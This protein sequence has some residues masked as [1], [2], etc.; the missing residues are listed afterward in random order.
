MSP[1]TIRRNFDVEV[2]MLFNQSFYLLGVLFC[3]SVYIERP[4]LNFNRQIKLLYASLK[5]G[6]F[7]IYIYINIW[8]YY[9]ASPYTYIAV[10][11]FNYITTQYCFTAMERTNLI[12]PLPRIYDDFYEIN[13][14][15]FPSENTTF[16][17]LHYIYFST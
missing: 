3:H 12:I 15:R 4:E 9:H 17:Q 2:I 14:R 5:F 16:V 10:V 11:L 7:R 13:N 8:Y 1:N 6:A